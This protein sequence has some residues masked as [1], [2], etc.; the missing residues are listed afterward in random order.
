MFLPPYYHI[1]SAQ[2]DKVY[3]VD[4]VRVELDKKKRCFYMIKPPFWLGTEV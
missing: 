3:V 4:A 2:I 1:I